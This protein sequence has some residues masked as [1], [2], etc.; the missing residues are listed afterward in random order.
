MAP[1]EAG[2]LF[3]FPNLWGDKRKHYG[4]VSCLASWALRPGVSPGNPGKSGDE[5]AGE[6]L[7]AATQNDDAP[8]RERARQLRR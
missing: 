2:K 6:R 8:V 7:L 3:R 4:H 5:D 1:L